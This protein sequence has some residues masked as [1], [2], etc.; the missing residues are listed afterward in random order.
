MNEQAIF[1][2]IKAKTDQLNSDDLIGKDL[3]ITITRITCAE[4]GEQRV[5][6]Y[7]AEGEGAKKPWKPCKGMLRVMVDAW[8]GDLSKW[9]GQ[10]VRLFRDETVKWAGAAV[11]G[12]R[13]R[14]MSGI[15]ANRT[16]AVTQSKGS[17]VQMKVARLEASTTKATPPAASKPAPEQQQEPETPFDD[18]APAEPAK[19][20]T[21]LE[22]LQQMPIG[23]TAAMSSFCASLEGGPV[24]LVALRMAVKALVLSRRDDTKNPIDGLAESERGPATMALKL[25]A[26]GEV[27]WCVHLVGLWKI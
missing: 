15:S 19:P 12:I 5:S 21:L 14:A 2:A 20:Q 25:G 18:D 7:F 22:A 13:I 6:I 4:S 24:D 3:D 17:K 1:D 27:G 23:G 26:K 8:T 11:G 16:F 9:K 10:R